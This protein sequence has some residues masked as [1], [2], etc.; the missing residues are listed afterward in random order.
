MNANDKRPDHIDAVVEALVFASDEPMSADA[1]RDAIASVDDVPIP[2]AWIDDAL[3]ALSARHSGDGTGF[4]LA[5]VAGGWEFRT[6][7]RVAPY[8]LRLFKRPPARLSRAALEVLAVV[9][10]RQPCT[11]ADVEDIRGVDCSGLL[12]ALLDR[13]LIRIIGKA[14]D[15]GRPLLYGTTT[16]FLS[17]FGLG[18]L[19][20][21][22]TLREYTELTEDHLVRL[23]ELDET[24]RASATSDRARDLGATESDSETAAADDGGTDEETTIDE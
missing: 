5:Q 17:F 18:S 9:A 22:P 1:I 19:S 8:V 14:D 7:T 15:I 21:L 10:Y 13:G 16:A 23:Q 4:Q 12:R 2:L 11:R 6:T 3:Q 20:D 24:L